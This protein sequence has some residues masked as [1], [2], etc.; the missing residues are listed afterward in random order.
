MA[1]KHTR[2]I[3]L[4]TAIL[5]LLF[6]SGCTLS[7][8]K[9]QDAG[10]FYSNDL[11]QTWKQ[12]I[13]VG[14]QNNK[15]STIGSLDTAFFVFHP[16][17]QNIIYLVTKTSGVYIT[18]N[19]GDQWQLTALRSGSY[20]AFALDPITPSIQYAA[21]GGSVIKSTDYGQTWNQIFIERP[22]VAINDVAVDPESP[23]RIWIANSTGGFLVSEDYGNTWKISMIFTDPIKKISIPRTSASTIYLQMVNQGIVKSSDRGATWDYSINTTLTPFAGAVPVTSLFILPKTND[24]LTISSA[25]GVLHSTD[26]GKTWKTLATVLPNSTVPINSAFIDPLNTDRI[27]FTAANIIYRSDDA[28]KTWKTLKTIPTTE[29]VTTLVFNANNPHDLFAGVTTIKK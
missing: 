2:T 24:N 6:V 23:S 26:G 16:T 13:Y 3:P 27:F 7:L 20:S 17:D 29:L 12:K 11:G 9:T 14:Q 5:F 15:V 10:V 22:G 1:P 4:T 28:G 19:K 21:Q 25:Y 8:S 18:T